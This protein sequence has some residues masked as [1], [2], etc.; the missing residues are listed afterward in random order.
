MSSHCHAS[1]MS[2]RAASPAAAPLSR[3]LSVLPAGSSSSSPSAPLLSHD[4]VHPLPSQQSLACDSV[5]CAFGF[6]C[7]C[8]CIHHREETDFLISLNKL[9]HYIC[10]PLCN[11]RKNVSFGKSG[12]F[13]YLK[14]DYGNAVVTRHWFNF[15]SLLK[16]VISFYIALTFPCS[17]KLWNNSRDKFRQKLGYNRERVLLDL[18]AVLRDSSLKSSKKE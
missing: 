4:K 12:R 2:F 17:L 3:V 10:C 9:A 8:V 6:E 5:K 1:A 7:V 16:N 14:T 18:W 11:K 15:C 13:C